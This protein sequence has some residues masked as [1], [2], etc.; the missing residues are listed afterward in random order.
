[1]SDYTPTGQV[2]RVV[3]GCC[4]DVGVLGSNPGALVADQDRVPR[5][6]SLV[7]EQLDGLAAQANSVLPFLSKE[8]TTM[9]RSAAATT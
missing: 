1:V 3:I 8:H 4:G 6:P 2:L 9:L 5:S 7:L